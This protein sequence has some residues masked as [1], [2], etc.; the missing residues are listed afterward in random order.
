MLNVNAH[1]FIHEMRPCRKRLAG[2]NLTK[3]QP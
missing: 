2:L 1:S 3:G